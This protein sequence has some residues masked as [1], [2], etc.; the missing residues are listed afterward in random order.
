MKAAD[1]LRRF[2]STDKVEV[3]SS[4]TLIISVRVDNIGRITNELF[5]NDIAVTGINTSDSGAE[6]YFIKKMEEE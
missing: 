6:R 1:I 5:N 2:L 3:T 4:N